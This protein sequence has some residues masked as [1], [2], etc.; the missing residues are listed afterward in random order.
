ML[1]IAVIIFREALE[2]S[3]IIGVLM[4]ATRGLA[5]RGRWIVG[6]LSAGLVGAVMV[7]VFA[8]RISNFAEG[9]GQ[10]L[11]NALILCLASALIIWTI[12]WMSRYGQKLAQEFKNLGAAI[13]TGIKPFHTLAVVVALAVLR[14]GSEIVLFTYGIL[15]QG[16]RA[17]SV[18]GGALLG[19]AVGASAGFAIYYGLVKISVKNLFSVTGWLLAFLAA[20]MLSQAATLLAAAGI[21]PEM[22][23]SVWDTSAFLSEHGFLGRVFHAL[24]G[25]SEKPSLLQ[26]ITY[27]L[28]IGVIVVLMR[29]FG[30]SS[31]SGSTK[32]VITS[33]AVLLALGAFFSPS[34]AWATKKVYLPYIDKGE[35]ELEYRGSYDWDNN[36]TKDGAQKHKFAVG[37][38]FTDFWFSEVYAELEKEPHK[39]SEAE[40]IEWENLFQLSEP[41]AWWVDTA[42]LVEYEFALHNE[43]ADNLECKLIF[44]KDYGKFLHSLNL[45][46][47]R[48]FGGRG[49]EGEDGEVEK[50]VH[51]L[52]GGFA[53]STRYRMA[54]EFEPGVEYHADLGSLEH[55]ENF[56]QQ[57][58]QVGPAI[59]GK[60]GNVKYDV[61]VLFGVSDAAPQ[62]E[63]KW[64]T[65]YE[66]RF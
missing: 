35:L 47:E 50:V 32:K 46:L 6:G 20:G 29:S 21:L 58:H 25:Y 45:T 39:N 34:Q 63:F 43:D 41:G 55:S 23:P 60:L 51:D 66:I 48:G 44:A 30:K 18:L 54:P 65:E 10:E 14:E 52:D 1:S 8:E 31:V 11:F 7:A 15:A 4:A 5:G 13:K 36:D 28:T 22:I 27:L 53:W 19:T 38:G 49:E 57:Q 3:I 9:M 37:Y 59:Y 64:I 26:L 56:N 24:L 33:F 16:E 12:I 61:G 40:A 42:F 17:S 2:I 62:V